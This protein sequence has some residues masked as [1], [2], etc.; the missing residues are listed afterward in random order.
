MEENNEYIN[1]Y[2]KSQNKHKKFHTLETLNEINGNI[3]KN[4]PGILYIFI[5]RNYISLIGVGI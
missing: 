3:L 1:K 4:I 5:Y 2:D